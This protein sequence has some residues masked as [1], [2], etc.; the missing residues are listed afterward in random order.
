LLNST[1]APAASRTPIFDFL[2]KQQGLHKLIVIRLRA[3]RCIDSTV[4][5]AAKR[6]YEVTLV[7]DAIASYRREEMKS[8]A[9][10]ERTELRD[11]YSFCRRSHFKAVNKQL[12]SEND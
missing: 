12:R 10:I 4:R 7:K 2:L 8:D 5:F 6:S 3:D 9:R 11:R 1:G